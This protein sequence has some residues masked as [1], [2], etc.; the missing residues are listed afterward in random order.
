MYLVNGTCLAIV[1]FEHIMKNISVSVRFQKAT[2]ET[3][4]CMFCQQGG[5]NKIPCLAGQ[6]R[7]PFLYFILQFYFI[8]FTRYD[9]IQSQL[10]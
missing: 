4:I 6:G 3:K 7:K 5:F 1:R 2:D 8:C 10:L 9:F